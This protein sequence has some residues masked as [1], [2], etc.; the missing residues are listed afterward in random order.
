MENKLKKET[1][2]VIKRLNESAMKSIMITGDNAL[3]AIS[4]AK[5]CQ[6]LKQENIIYLADLQ[7]ENDPNSK[8][9]WS[10]IN[11]DND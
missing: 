7:N 8:I 10:R 6:I 5:K 9:I 4:V 2:G 1:V 11:P 3:T